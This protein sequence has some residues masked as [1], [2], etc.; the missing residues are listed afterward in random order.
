MGNLNKIHGH[1]N[2]RLYNIWARMKQRCENP[3]LYGY[4]DYGG[5]GITVCAEWHE[6]T[7]FYDWAMTHG[8]KENLTIDRIDLNGN[9]EPSNC[10]WVTMKVQ[11][12]NKRRNHLI[13]L[14]GETHTISEWARITGINKSTIRNRIVLYGWNI[15]KALTTI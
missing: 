14:N 1:K 9:Y 11:A 6:F 3:K 7:P 2:D 8:Y 5:R 12:N 10:R 15:E 13:T 4:K